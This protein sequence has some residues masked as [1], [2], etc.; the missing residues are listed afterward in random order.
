MNWRLLKYWQ[1]ASNICLQPL[2]LLNNKWVKEKIP[3][4]H[5]DLSHRPLNFWS[6]ATLSKGDRYLCSWVVTECGTWPEIEWPVVSNPGSGRVFF[7]SPICLFRRSRG[8]KYML[9]ADCQYFR[10]LQFII[11]SSSL[12]LLYCKAIIIQ[13]S[14]KKDKI[15]VKSDVKSSSN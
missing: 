11:T 1:S 6:S 12:I 3:F 14:T 8:C 5:L 13:P 2:D 4:Y 10:S 9:L 15:L 7:L